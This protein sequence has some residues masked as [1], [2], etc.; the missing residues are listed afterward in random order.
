MEL[1]QFQTVEGP[2]PNG[3]LAVTFYH[4]DTGAT[5]EILRQRVW[6]VAQAY[7]KDAE[8]AE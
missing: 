2:Y 5:A 4:D 3:V 6:Q 1:S 8:E 7:R